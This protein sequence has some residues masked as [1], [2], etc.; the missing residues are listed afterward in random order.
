M[1]KS[2]RDALTTWN[3]KGTPIED[4]DLAY[5]EAQTTY[6]TALGDANKM[7][8]YGWILFGL[9]WVFIGLGIIIYV[10]KKPKVV[11]S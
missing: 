8:A 11:Q 5:K 9:G 6:Y 1:Q 7:N 3:D 10:F 4:A 2:A